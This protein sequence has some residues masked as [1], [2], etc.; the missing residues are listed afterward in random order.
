[1][2]SFLRVIITLNPALDKMRMSNC[3]VGVV[4]KRRDVHWSF[5]LL[6][7]ASLRAG[8]FAVLVVDA[9]SKARTVDHVAMRVGEW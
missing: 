1:M 7:D 6:S 8:A 3:R 9:A 4:G 5:F 2:M